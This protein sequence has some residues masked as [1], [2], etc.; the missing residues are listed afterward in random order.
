ML[1]M[2]CL[3]MRRDLYGEI[4]PLDEQFKVGMFED[5][6]YSLRV[7][8]RGYRVICAE[9]VF[10]HH[11]GRASFSRLNHQEY[12]RVFNENRRRF[13]AKWNIKWQLPSAR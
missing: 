10:V 8:N 7:R 11:A 13:E 3:A 6:D 12:E 2:Y 1:A 4:G 9:D 5:D